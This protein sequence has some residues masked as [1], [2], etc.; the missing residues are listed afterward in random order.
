[1]S[2]FLF[3]LNEYANY[4]YRRIWN[5]PVNPVRPC[6]WFYGGERQIARLATPVLWLLPLTSQHLN[7][8]F[9]I[10][11]IFKI[12][13][14]VVTIKRKNCRD[15][16]RH[17]PS[18]NRYGFANRCNFFV[19]FWCIVMPTHGGGGGGI[20]RGRDGEGWK[21]EMMIMWGWWWND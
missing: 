12:L 17:S 14:E 13:L 20:L 1:L 10:T 9:P 8:Q 11:L 18:F 6:P 19:P 3:L 5:L 7:F 21:H 2:Q 16:S 4:L 15:G